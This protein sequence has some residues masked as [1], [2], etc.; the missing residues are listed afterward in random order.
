MR[1][2]SLPDTVLQLYRKQPPV[3]DVLLNIF[4]TIRN[5]LGFCSVGFRVLLTVHSFRLVLG[6]LL[7]QVPT[8][9][10]FTCVRNFDSLLPQCS[11]VALFQPLWP[12]SLSLLLLLPS[13]LELCPYR[14][15]P[16]SPLDHRLLR[17]QRPLRDP[18]MHSQ[19][20]QPLATVL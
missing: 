1:V 20:W 18:Q 11:L 6:L 19:Q 2:I 12:H 9:T 13:R 4:I 3:S 17:E 15:L 16:Q 5:L 10:F 7:G 14:I 8:I